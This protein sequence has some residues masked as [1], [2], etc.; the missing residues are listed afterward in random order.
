MKLKY[1]LSIL[2]CLTC[3]TIE[4]QQVYTLEMCRNI[5]L[6]NNKTAIIASL[7]DEKTALE[8]K[9]YLSNFFPKISAQGL[10][11]WTNTKWEQHIDETLLP[12]YLFDPASG[13]VAPNIAKSPLD[14]SPII[15]QNGLPVFNSYGLLPS[16]DLSF[17]LNNSW[18]AGVQAEQPIFMGGKIITAYRM[19][20]IGR[21][22]SHQNI[23]L[24]RNQIILQTDQAFFLHLKALES[25]KV[26]KA[27]RDV[28]AELFKNVEAA[29]KN[30]MKQYNDVL[31]VQV[32]LNKADLQL[33]KAENGIRLTRMNLCQIIGLP[34][35]SDIAISDSIDT[36][37]FELQKDIPVSVRPESEILNKQLELKTQQI[38]LVRSD[39]LPSI[40][41]LTN[42]GYMRGIDYNFGISNLGNYSGHL[43]DNFSFSAL[44]SVKIP[45]F[46][47][48]EGY[49]K[50][51]VARAEKQIMSLQ[52][53]DLDE[54]MELEKQQAI[55]RLTESRLEV[56]LTESALLQAKDNLE[57]SRRYY[58][59]GMETLAGYLEAQTIWQQTWLEN[60]EAKINLKLNETIYKKT[61]GEL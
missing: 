36:Q 10:Y 39:F 33:H 1:C 50:I 19:S 34:V 8:S 13:T 5:A 42:Y 32:Q 54:K 14:G 53:A 57:S 45:L 40:G 60:I 30:G 15:D 12:T 24:T 48:G 25:L 35:D 6:T 52:K 9:S 2:F 47:W 22:I 31:K 37:Y 7:A 51:K 17:S 23:Y 28:V 59:N 46:N 44:L 3:V 29:Q 61:V 27:F 56:R 41:L 11:L 55:D 49:H 20:K 38:R 43:I 18:F 4:A 16:M 26:A 58:E 21:E